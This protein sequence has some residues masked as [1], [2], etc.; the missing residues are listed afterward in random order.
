MNINNVNRCGV[1][2]NDDY[3]TSKNIMHRHSRD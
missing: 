1:W 2:K 3:M